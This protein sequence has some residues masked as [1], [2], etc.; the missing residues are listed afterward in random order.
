MARSSHPTT[1]PHYWLSI[2]W[3]H[4]FEFGFIITFMD[5]TI[6]PWEPLSLLVVS[7]IPVNGPHHW[8]VIRWF[9]SMFD[10]NTFLHM[11][12]F[13]RWSGRDGVQDPESCLF[14][15]RL[16]G[17]ICHSWLYTFLYYMNGCDHTV[18]LYIDDDPCYLDGC[19]HT[20]IHVLLFRVFSDVY[21][22]MLSCRF[23]DDGL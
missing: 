10:F 15:L 16:H 23:S 14:W 4:V 22:S 1:G 9:S 19:A 13:V 12:G 7:L 21:V 20:M 6:V 2:R 3:F 8:P 11:L 5:C 17:V 18:G